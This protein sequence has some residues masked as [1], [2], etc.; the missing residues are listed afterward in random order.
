[1][2]QPWWVQGSS[3]K[4]PK[5]TRIQPVL[6]PSDRASVIAEIDARMAAY[7]PEWTARTADDAGIALVTL[8]G[9]MMEPV[10]TRLNQLPMKA[11]VEALRIVGIDPLPAEPASVQLQFTILDSATGPALVP[12]GFQVAGRSTDGTGDLITFETQY[13][14]FA[15][16]A[17]IAQVQVQDGSFFINTTPDPN[18]PVPFLPFGASAK[19]GGALYLGLSDGP[20][21]LQISIGIEVVT[22]AGT[23]TP[24][25]SGGLTPLPSLPS[26]TLIWEAYDGSS[27]SFQTAPVVSDGTLELVQSGVVV[28]TVPPIWNPGAPPGLD[29]ASAG[30]LL[31]LRLRIVQ[32]QFEPA[33]MISD[34]LLNVVQALAVQTITGEFVDFGSDTTLQTATLSQTPVLDGSLII[35]VVDDPLSATDSSQWKETDDLQLAKPDDQV[36]EFDPATGEITFGDGVH[37]VAIPPGFRNVLA[38]YKAISPSSGVLAANSVTTLISSAPFVT[39][40]NN[41]N[42]GSGG[43]TI[44]SQ[45]EAIARGPQVFRS[46]GR[47]VTTDDFALLATQAAGIVRAHA[48]ACHHPAYPGKPIPGVVGVYVIPPDTNPTHGQGAAPIPTSETLAAVSKYLSTSAALAGVDIVVAAPVY[49]FVKAQIAVVANPTALVATVYQGVLT[50]LTNYLHPITGGDDGN[51]WPFGETLLYTRMLLFLLTNVPGIRAIPSLTLTIDGQQLAPCSNFPIG[52]DSVF[53]SLQH[54]IVP[55]GEEGGS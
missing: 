1:M 33:P 3:V 32:G 55:S 13:D 21:Q 41:P 8:F 31:W 24:F 44:G 46:R 18:V 27:G 54:E 28:L 15:T 39:E 52:E 50:K 10:L 45:A 11:F 17:T 30:S 36:Y 20:P 38:N 35:T 23:P 16:T 42:P 22:S 19:A 14:L 6:L 51:G 26:P 47:A 34:V 43:T 7:T 49:H 4:P 2:S 37:G 12:K 25:A 29:P 53:W 9:G 5:T 40:V 48:I